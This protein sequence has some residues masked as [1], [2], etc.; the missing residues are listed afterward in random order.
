MKLL[1][2]NQE[3]KILK[4]NAVKDGSVDYKYFLNI[5]GFK[6]RKEDMLQNTSR[7]FENMVI[8]PVKEGLSETTMRITNVTIMMIRD[9]YLR[10]LRRRHLGCMFLPVNVVISEVYKNLCIQEHIN[11]ICLGV[12]YKKDHSFINTEEFEEIVKYLGKYNT[13]EMP[14]NRPKPEND[15]KSLIK[16][17]LSK[18]TFTNTSQDKLDLKSLFW[19]HKLQDYLL[20]SDEKWMLDQYNLVKRFLLQN[21]VDSN[22]LEFSDPIYNNYE[23][24][25]KMKAKAI[26]TKEVHF[27][28]NVTRNLDGLN[29]KEL[30]DKY[31]DQTATNYIQTEFYNNYMTEDKAMSTRLNFKKIDVNALADTFTE[32]E[33]FLSMKEILTN[34]KL[35]SQNLKQVD[36][37]KLRENKRYV[38]NQ[39]AMVHF[40]RNHSSI[41]QVQEKFEK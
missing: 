20:K 18:L 1:H 31:N 3:E 9:N 27:T 29:V 24:V 19:R 30:Y 23:F 6:E 41:S 28:R 40:G 33:R 14:E 36:I 2:D 15:M 39:L 25:R 10:M 11:Y 32:I 22:I 12:S 21:S 8:N 37:E 5:Y 7:M 16:R 17:K 26:K 13:D 35:N 4:H 38:R 34:K